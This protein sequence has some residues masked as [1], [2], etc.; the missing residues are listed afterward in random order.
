MLTLGQ[1]QT[2][3]SQERRCT[4]TLAQ[5]PT[6]RGFKLGMT[7]DEVLALF[8]G[9]KDSLAIR[10]AL[11]YAPQQFGLARFSVSP[12]RDDKPFEG[13]NQVDFEF[14]DNQL[15]SFYISYNGPEWDEVSQFVSVLSAS[16]KLPG[17]EYWERR[18]ENQRTLK[19]TGFQVT[20][21]SVGNGGNSN[22]VKVSNPLA[23][24]TVLD[25]QN[26][27]REK[28]RQAFRP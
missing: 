19:C 12:T 13:I 16:L 26:E 6:I 14:L 4:L 28:A 24:Q 8:P 27:A 17:V 20:A 22:Y 18:S 11:S 5:S 15:T 23:P 2:E 10:N 1:T 25:R 21:V 9:R 3:G 7:T